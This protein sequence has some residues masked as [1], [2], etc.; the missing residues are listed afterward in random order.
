MISFVSSQ[1]ILIGDLPIVASGIARGREPGAT[2]PC[3]A[4]YSRPRRFPCRKNLRARVAQGFL[5]TRPAGWQWLCAPVHGPLSP[6]A[7]Y[8]ARAF[9]PWYHEVL[10]QTAPFFPRRGSV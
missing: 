2:S 8:P 10:R 9:H 5:E 6:A 1:F 7:A 4:V 3:L